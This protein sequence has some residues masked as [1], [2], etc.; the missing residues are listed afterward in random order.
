MEIKPRKQ[1]K[2]KLDTTSVL[3]NNTSVSDFSFENGKT[4]GVEEDTENRLNYEATFDM[5]IDADHSINE[6]NGIESSILSSDVDAQVESFLRTTR[7]E[8]GRTIF[9]CAECN[10]VAKHR[11]NMRSHIETHLEGLSF[12]CQGCERSYKTRNSLKKHMYTTDK[13]K[14][15]KLV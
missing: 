3:E 8:E 7:T 13:C 9:H 1:Y 12:P 15:N 4:I 2:K 6:Y 10:K 14:P 11:Q 5:A